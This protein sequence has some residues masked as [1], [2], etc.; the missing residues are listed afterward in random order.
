MPRG[1][2]ERKTSSNCMG[3]SRL[4]PLRDHLVKLSLPD[5]LFIAVVTSLIKLGYRSITLNSKIRGGVPL[6]RICDQYSC[7]S[8]CLVIGSK[9][10]EST[11]IEFFFW[12]KCALILFYLAWF[13]LISC[14]WM[15]CSSFYFIPF[16]LMQRGLTFQ[17]ILRSWYLAK[18][19]AL[20]Y[21]R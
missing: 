20:R 12:P 21:A 10:T 7:I 6:C 17:S 14:V 16:N 18:F 2:G 8:A 15:D 1:G 13:D 3:A 5:F 9:S 11:F 4:F 19:A